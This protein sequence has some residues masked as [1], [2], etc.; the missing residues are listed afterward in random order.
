MGMGFTQ[1]PEGQ[2]IS[3]AT[4]VD[5]IAMFLD[6]LHINAVDLVGN[7]SGGLLAQLFVA[8]FPERVRTLLLTNCDVDEDNP[9]AALAPIVEQA[10]KGVWVD[11]N[12]IPLL[13]DK[14]LARSPK[15]LGTIYAHPENLT[16]EII[17]TYFR[18]LTASPLRKSQVEQYAI[19]LATNELVAIRENLSRWKGA[20]RMVWGLDDTTFEVK[21][22]E[23]LDRTLPGS[24]GVRRVEG[25][26]LFF[27]EEMP[28]LMAGEA[29]TLW[30][31]ARRSVN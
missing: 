5:M 26:K 6:A 10:K 9:P 16:D 7:D 17:E 2:A 3:P 14:Q 19:S 31:I 27:P 28:E 25:A 15:A 1:T 24:Q 20:A 18:P 21:W 8:K 29:A 12:L 13:D 4:Q 30:G 11:R 22:A 23:W